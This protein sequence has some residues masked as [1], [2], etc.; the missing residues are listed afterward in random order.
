MNGVPLF[1][2]LLCCFLVISADLLFVGCI[3][4]R[5]YARMIESIQNSPVAL[6]RLPAL[7]ASLSVCVGLWGISLV[8][9]D[10]WNQTNQ[11]NATIFGF[12]SFLIYNATNLSVFTNWSARNAVLDTLYGTMLCTVTYLIVV[13]LIH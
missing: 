5:P 2:F 9:A 12:A 4:R 10:G 6:R 8:D 11:R 13:T 3:M 1:R 7:L